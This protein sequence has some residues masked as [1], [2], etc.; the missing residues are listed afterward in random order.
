[1]KPIISAW[2]TTAILTIPAL[3]VSALVWLNTAAANEPS[4]FAMQGVSAS[5]CYLKDFQ[6]KDP[7][8]AKL[9][10]ATDA[11]WWI[12][13]DGEDP[14]KAGCHIEVAGAADAKPRSKG[15]VFGEACET[16]NILIETNPGVNKIHAHSGDKGNPFRID[17][18][19]WCQKQAAPK[20]KKGSCRPERVTVR[21]QSKDVTCQSAKCVCE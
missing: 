9:K 7:P 15:R 6:P 8:P 4:C 11:T 21:Y 3:V 19:K 14:G 17:C 1:M 20:N 2:S 18:D 10:S 16:S 13:T 12:D 5:P